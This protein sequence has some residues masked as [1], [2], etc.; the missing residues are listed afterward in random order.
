M[1]RQLSYSSWQNQQPGRPPITTAVTPPLRNADFLSK[2]LQVRHYSNLTDYRRGYGRKE[3]CLLR[4]RLC[5]KM[6]APALMAD[7]PD[8]PP[9]DSEVEITPLVQ[10]WSPPGTTAFAHAVIML[11]PQATRRLPLW[12][13][14]TKRKTSD[15]GETPFGISAR[16]GSP[17]R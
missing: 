7:A 14:T 13:H 16:R 17:H 1:K 12:L 15:C 10:P 9:N 5:S 3:P 8:V 6:A 2:P 4:C 11:S